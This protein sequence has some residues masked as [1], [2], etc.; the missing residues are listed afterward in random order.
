MVEGHSVRWRGDSGSSNESSRTQETAITSPSHSTAPA[1][2]SSCASSWAQE[3]AVAPS[4]YPSTQAF[5][6]RASIDSVQ[7]SDSNFEESASDLQPKDIPYSSEQYVESD[8]LPATSRD[9]AE[10][11]PSSRK[12]MIRHDDT[13]IDGNKNL[14]VDTTVKTTRGLLRDLTLFHLRMYN[15]KSRD[16]SVRR[17]CRDS[18][19]EVCHCVR[20]SHTTKPTSRPNIQRSLSNA[21][22][23][24]IPKVDNKPNGREKVEHL[25][26]NSSTSENAQQDD[27]EDTVPPHSHTAA[28]RSKSNILS[29]E[30]SNY[31][32]V[33]LKRRGIKTDKHYDFD[34]WDSSYSWHR[35]TQRMGNSHEI[36]YYLTRKDGELVARISPEPLSTAEARLEKQKGGWIPP[37]S[38][39]IVDQKIK[40]YQDGDVADVIVSTGLSVLVD[41][42]IRRHFHTQE[43]SRKGIQIPFANVRLSHKDRSFSAGGLDILQGWTHRKFI[44]NSL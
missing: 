36:S 37:C 27:V 15:L 17:Y 3:R 14:R 16:L 5:E 33:D 4:P 23:A 31:A 29:L 26:P 34:Y 2:E 43:Q 20:K 13:T 28:T 41:D 1:S 22:A 40:D 24:M 18:G 38:L 11:F 32:H 10:L 9:F 25:E 39:R 35:S 42:C 44:P 7:T 6:S 30:F 8:V 19:R 21:F 12:L